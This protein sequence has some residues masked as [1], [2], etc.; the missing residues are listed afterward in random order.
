MSESRVPSTN[1]EGLERNP[2]LNK[3]RA[4]APCRKPGPHPLGWPQRRPAAGVVVDAPQ[5]GSPEVAVVEV[6]QCYSGRSRW[7]E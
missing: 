3:D 4:M 1:T 2:H 6:T 5:A 7:Y